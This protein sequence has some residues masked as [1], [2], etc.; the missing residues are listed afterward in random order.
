MSSKESFF[1]YDG[2][3]LP[4][5]DHIPTPIGFFFT[6]VREK[7]HI[8]DISSTTSLRPKYIPHL[9]NVVKE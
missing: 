8:V 9:V 1:K 3:I 4:I 7:Q 6:N 5:I 2:E